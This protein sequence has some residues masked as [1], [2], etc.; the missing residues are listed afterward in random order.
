M[1]H[2][3]FN[4]MFLGSYTVYTLIIAGLIGLSAGF[5]TRLAIN[6]KQK[7]NILKLENE[8]LSNHS[9]I[10]SLEKKI[11]TLE[12]E[13]LELGKNNHKKVELKAS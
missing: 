13:N 5:F 6:A 1:T 9:R 8:M 7:R 2:T 4:L 10:L 11:S 3:T 12:K